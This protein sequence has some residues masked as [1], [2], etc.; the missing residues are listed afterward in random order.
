MRRLIEKYEVVSRYAAHQVERSLWKQVEA[1]LRRE[2]RARLGI[3]GGWSPMDP[4]R[5][6]PPSSGGAGG[7]A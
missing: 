7:Q 6:D 3:G 4:G 2:R 1:A 5:P